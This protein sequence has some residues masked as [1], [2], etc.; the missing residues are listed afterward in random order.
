MG[1]S[2]FLLMQIRGCVPDTIKMQRVPFNPAWRG[3]AQML[4]P[5]ECR[6]VKVVVV[7]VSGQWSG[8]PDWAISI[9]HTT[10]TMAPS[11]PGVTSEPLHSASRFDTI[12]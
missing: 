2:L 3:P 11:F 1:E 10:V 9:P 7:G 8:A 12:D 4:Q 5:R 6:S